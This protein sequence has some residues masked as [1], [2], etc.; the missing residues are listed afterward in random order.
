MRKPIVAL[1]G[2]PNVGKSTLFNRIIGHRLA[3]VE[4]LPGTTRDRQYADAEWTAAPFTLV[5]TGGI[6]LLEGLDRQARRGS[7]PLAANSAGFRREI[8]AQAEL[9]IDE[10]DV[11]VFMVD[12]REGVTA[13]DRD[14][15]DVLR[16]TTKPVVLAANKADNPERR[17]A[18]VEFYELGLGEPYP[19]SSIHGTGV[20]DL[21]DAVVAHLPKVDEEEDEEALKIAIIGR[22]NV[23]KSSLLNA[24]LG[25]ERVIVSEIPGTTR[26]AIDTKLHWQGQPVTLID[27]AGIRRRGRVEPGV[28][29]YSVM[30]ALRAVQ[31]ADV[32]AL[33]IDAT[34]G[35][36]DQDSHIAG[37]VL[38]DWKSLMIL[39]NKWDLVAK[40]TYTM[41]Q[42]TQEIRGQLKFLDFVPLLFISALTKQRV[43]KVIPLAQTIV[44]HR[45]LRIPTAELNRII[46]EAFA[47]H[48]LPSKT[49]KR[50]RFFYA[51][52]AETSPPTF[53]IFVNDAKLVHFTYQRYLENRLRERYPFEGTP[54]KLVF[55]SRRES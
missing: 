3:I 14:V 25:Q 44:A 11:I 27:T 40:D 22:P 47:R 2:R 52:Q 6:E 28:E 51:T 39:V 26:D 1:V 36:T 20:G 19:V 31:R 42:F 54:L 7:T 32:V 29:K 49:G 9:A 41:H 13:G 45:Q 10:A 4:D 43:N 24:L 30:R 15:A 5:D 34:Q 16:R 55:R 35:V 38:E 17:M 50:L 21:L 46:Q 18:A 37:Y 53:V 23:G 33:L 48:Q 12:A 8:R